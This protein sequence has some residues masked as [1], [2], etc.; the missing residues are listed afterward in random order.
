SSVEVQGLSYTALSGSRGM[1]AAIRPRSSAGKPHESTLPGLD[2]GPL[3]LGPRHVDLAEGLAVDLDPTLADQA[4]RL[5]RRA[6]P[7]VLDEQGRQMDGIA[8]GQRRLGHLLRRLVFADDA[9]EV[10]LD[11]K[12]TRLNSSHVAISYAVFCLKKKN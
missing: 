3:E 1:I 12:S 2:E 9:G 7:E 10:L 11:R 6:Q 5:A 8:F 4:P